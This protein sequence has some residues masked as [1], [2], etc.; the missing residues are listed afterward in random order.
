[1]ETTPT[2]TPQLEKVREYLA[3]EGFRPRIEKDD[4]FL[5]YR[6]WT[7]VVTNDCDDTSYYYVLVP[8]F[9]E[10]ESNA[11]RLQALETASEMSRIYKV[12]KV[13]L[14]GDNANVSA[15]TGAFATTPEAFL[16]VVVRCISITT[17][18]VEEFRKTMNDRSKAAALPA[19]D[20]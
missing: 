16:D 10:I 3:E 17:A 20:A 8:F 14:T 6:G 4:L 13:F 7:V 18:A 1:M 11:E 5:T 19:P 12:T 9:W 2:I 15:M